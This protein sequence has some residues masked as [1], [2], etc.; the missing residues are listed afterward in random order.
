MY[1]VPAVGSARLRQI[2]NALPSEPLYGEPPDP[3][4]DASPTCIKAAHLCA[5]LSEKRFRIGGVRSCKIA[6]GNHT[7]L[8]V[9]RVFGSNNQ[10]TWC[11]DPRKREEEGE[12]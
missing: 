10:R 8:D 1:F 2:W 4:C 3:W 5:A 6:S 7:K 9:G 12:G 11:K